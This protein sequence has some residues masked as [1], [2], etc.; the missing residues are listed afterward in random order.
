MHLVVDKELCKKVVKTID[1]MAASDENSRYTFTNFC[2]KKNLFSEQDKVLR[3]G[4]LFICC[5]FHHDESPSLGINEERRIWNCLGC[6]KHGRFID[7][8]RYYSMDVEGRDISYYQQVN[9]LLKDDIE[10]QNKVG[11]STIYKVDKPQNSF[12]GAE[13]RSFKISHPK[14]STYPELASWMKSKK[15]NKKMIIFALLQMQSGVPADSIYNSISNNH[16]VTSNDFDNK[17][18]QYDVSDILAD[19]NRHKEQED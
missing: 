14:P 6:A 1:S 12:K 16:T 18:V 7:F 10:L 3:S 2:K 17:K 4:N 5:P 8:V 19:S 15:F 13:Y 11:A 9:E